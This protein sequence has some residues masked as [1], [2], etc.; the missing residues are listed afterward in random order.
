MTNKP[1][2]LGMLAGLFLAVGL[3][4]SSMLVTRAWLKVSE[5]QTI[6]VTGSAR[7]NIK[8]DLII[9]RASFSGEGDSL[10]AAQAQLKESRG[11]VEAFVKASGVT[12]SEFSSVAITDLREM[13][14]DSDH[15][16][17]SVLV[18]YR[19]TQSVEVQSADVENVSRLDRNSTELIEQGVFLTSFPPQYIYTRAGEAKVEMLAEAT[20][21]A[22]ARAEQIGSQG[23]RGISQLQN[24]RMGVF[25]IAPLYSTET[26]WDGMND[27]TSLDKTVTA[28]VSATFSLR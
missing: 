2:L 15:T 5:T 24:A 26:S 12:N 13:R 22:R 1:Q 20:R 14:K 17:Q 6:S 7:K 27:T 25:Q 19:L 10:A 28:V 18:G 8:S 23:G 3:V 4:C 9:W 11:K 21:D 16:Q